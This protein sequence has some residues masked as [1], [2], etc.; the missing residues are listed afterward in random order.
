MTGSFQQAKVSLVSGQ[1]RPGLGFYETWDSFFLDL[2]NPDEREGLG[3]FFLLQDTM[4]LPP[5][6]SKGGQRLLQR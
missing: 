4:R 6:K 5:C 3:T 2:K 1:L